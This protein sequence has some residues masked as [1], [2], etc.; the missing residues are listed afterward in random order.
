MAGLRWHIA[1]FFASLFA[2]V[3]MSQ[4]ELAQG[5]QSALYA[6]DKDKQTIKKRNIIYRSGS[7]V[8]W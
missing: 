3:I 8:Q 2:E 5:L 6:I 4:N 1:F 7:S